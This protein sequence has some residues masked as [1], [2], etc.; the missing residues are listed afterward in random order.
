MSINFKYDLRNLIPTRDED[1]MVV[2]YNGDKNHL[3]PAPR[4]DTSL[5]QNIS[6]MQGLVVLIISLEI[7]GSTPPSQNRPPVCLS[8]NVTVINK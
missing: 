6:P 7:P 3:S 2:I 8:C 1:V 4:I 5:P